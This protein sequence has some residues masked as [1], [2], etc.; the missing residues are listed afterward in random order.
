LDAAQYP[1]YRLLEATL[2]KFG[3]RWDALGT[4]PAWRSQR[5]TPRAIAVYRLRGHEGRPRGKIAIGLGDKLGKS[6]EL[7][8]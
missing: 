5:L 2:A 8:P 4:Y 1:E 3:E 6:L 7:K